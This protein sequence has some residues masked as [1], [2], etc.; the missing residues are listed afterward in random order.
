MKIVDKTSESLKRSYNIFVSREELDASVDDLLQEK[1]K[2]AR[3][4][5]FRPG[6]VPLDIIRR[7]YG[8][9]ASLESKKT[10]IT[11]AAK[12]VLQDENLAVSINYTTDIVKEDENGLEFVMKFEVIPEFKLKDISKLEVE[13][14]IPEIDEKEADGLLEAIRK[15]HK[16]WQEDKLAKKVEKEQKIIIDLYCLQNEKNKKDRKISDLEIIVGESDLVDDFSKHFLGA[17]ISET[18]EFSINY[19]TNFKDKALAGKN[20]KHKAIVKKILKAT[21]YELDNSFAKSLGYGDI[22][23]AKEWAKPFVVAKYSR[24]SDE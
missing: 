12:K 6:K 13:K 20:I 10:S 21:E 14:L 2:K 8:E 9:S 24:I 19:P 23:K 5:G 17:K 16:N 11:R 1:A 22:N 18:R 3:L 7:M 4:D 15:E